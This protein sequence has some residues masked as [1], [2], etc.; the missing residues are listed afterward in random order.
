MPASW[1]PGHKVATPEV[2]STL[3]DAIRSGYRKKAAVLITDLLERNAQDDSIGDYWLVVARAAQ[4]IGELGY[5]DTAAS[6]FVDRNKRDLTRALL[7]AGLLAEIG[8]FHKAIELARPF[9]KSNPKDPS[10]NHLL[11]T[12]YQQLGETDRASKHLAHAVAAAP[13]SG[14]SWLTLAAQHRFETGDQLL[15]RLREL[16]PSMERTEAQ[17]R[18]HYH[19]AHGKALLDIGEHDLAFDEFEKGAELAPGRGRYDADKENAAVR[20]IVEG[21]RQL[22]AMTDQSQSERPIFVV[23]LPRTGTTLLQRILM[24]DESVAA[25]GEF[26]GMSIATMEIRRQGYDTWSALAGLPDAGSEFVRDLAETYLNLLTQ[27]FGDEGR[28]VDKSITNT[29]HVGLIATAFPEAPIILVERD[30]LDTAWSCFRTCFNQGLH[31][32][33][34]QKDIAAHFLNERKL[35][36]HW[37]KTLG[38]R[39]SVVK[40]EELVSKPGDVLQPLFERC[41][42]KFSDDILS[43]HET[44]SPVTTAS[45]VQVNQPLTTAAVGLA[46]PVRERLREFTA[47]CE[48]A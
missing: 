46:E 37:K 5:A 12:I 9:L 1:G 48:K 29:R 43:F 3:F 11:G 21:H 10:L 33:W 14:I 26:G 39:I 2:I 19:Y 42:L 27:R 23:G 4:R 44:K 40:Y 13:F 34:S 28:I 15:A 32:S 36:D 47:A 30:P 22:P 7:G 17:N 35:L 18:C 16:A 8:R 24:A 25:G 6:H 31:W 38:D 41:E 45:V 20:R